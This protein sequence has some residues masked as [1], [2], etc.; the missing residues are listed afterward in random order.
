[1]SDKY[2]FQPPKRDVFSNRIEK[3]VLA[4]TGPYNVYIY[5]AT[6]YLKLWSCNESAH[7]FII[8]DVLEL[9]GKNIA[10]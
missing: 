5:L 3:Y 4:N 2:L 1:M 8:K 7:T 6:K 9:I 10:S